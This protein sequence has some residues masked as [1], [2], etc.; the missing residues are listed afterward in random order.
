MN[1]FIIQV[2]RTPVPEDERLTCDDL[3]E[4]CMSTIF[5]SVRDCDNSDRKTAIKELA[6]CFGENCVE[7]ET[8]KI[9]T[10]LKRKY[11]KATFACAMSC[12]ANLQRAFF[13]VVGGS[14]DKNEPDF[15]SLLERLQSIVDQSDT[16]LIYEEGTTGG[17]PWTIDKWLRNALDNDE[18]EATFYI[19]GV[20][21]YHY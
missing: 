5:D 9:S 7:G 6:G 3:P 18:E 11:F 21:D 17:K 19:G 4:Y 15:E 14:D 2:S 8:L 16:L 1:D 13:D 12:I 10:A 20:L